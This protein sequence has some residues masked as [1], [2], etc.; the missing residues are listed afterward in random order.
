M[1]TY[2]LSKRFFDHIFESF[3]AKTFDISLFFYIVDLANRL[4]WKELIDLPTRLTMAGTKIGAY[5]TYKRSLENLTKW[6]FIDWIY[7][8]KNDTYAANVIKLNCFVEN[9]E[10]PIKAF[11]KAVNMH[12]QSNDEV[13]ASTININSLNFKPETIMNIFFEEEDFIKYQNLKVN[14]QKLIIENLKVLLNRNLDLLAEHDLSQIEFEIKLR[15]EISSNFNEKEK[16]VV[17]D[18]QDYFGINELNNYRLLAMVNHFVQYLSQSNHLELF[19]ENF[20]F[21]RKYKEI[22]GQTSHSFER[23][24]GTTDKKYEDGAWQSENFKNKVKQYEN[25]QFFSSRQKGKKTE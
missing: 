23:F 10:A 13:D 17:D 12:Y 19:T 24:I 21:Y 1:N 8:A 4:G 14:K 3:E 18:I 16:K 15:A 6:G 9:V 2:K 25:N 20:F 5:P 11:T 7:K 22:T